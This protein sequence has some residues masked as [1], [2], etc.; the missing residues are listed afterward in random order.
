MGVVTGP[1]AI[2]LGIIALVQIKNNPEKHA[3]KPMAIT[4]IVTGA[5]YFLIVAIFV[6][7]AIAMQGAK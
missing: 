7:I 5:V 3:G 1:I 6:L 4:G 2:V